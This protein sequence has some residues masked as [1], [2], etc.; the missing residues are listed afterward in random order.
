MFLTVIIGLS[1][2]HQEGRYFFA[3]PCA[4]PV[5]GDHSEKHFEQDGSS[6]MFGGIIKLGASKKVFSGKVKADEAN[7][8]TKTYLMLQ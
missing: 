5:A 1:I 3:D 6:F 2:F 4:N 7:R 8:Y